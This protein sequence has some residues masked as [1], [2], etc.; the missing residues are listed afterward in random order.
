[1]A[2]LLAS[3]LL[4]AGL[5]A[6]ADMIEPPTAAQLAIPR[7][8]RFDLRQYGGKAGGEALNTAAFEAAVAAIKK[9]GGGELYVP[10]GVWL[11]TGFALTSHMSLFLEKGA[12]IL[13][14]LPNNTH[15]RPRNESCSSYPA[16]IS[17]RG[18]PGTHS[19][20]P[21]N[22]DERHSGYEPIIGGINLTDVHI[23]GNNGTIA[24][25]GDYWWA[26]I[27]GHAAPDGSTCAKP[28]PAKWCALPHGRPHA[29]LMSRCQ[30]VM[31]SNITIT[32]SPFW[33]IRFWASQQLRASDLT[34]TATRTSMNNDGIDVDSSSDAVIENLYYDGGDDGVA[35]KSGECDAG[36]D[37]NTPTTNVRISHVSARTR[38]SC[39]VTGSEDQGGVHNVTV[40]DYA[41]RDSPGGIILK[42]TTLPH[43]AG[44]AEIGFPKSN[45]SFAGVHLHNMSTYWNGQLQTGQGVAIQGVRGFT[46]ANID[47]DVSPGALGSIQ[48]RPSQTCST[49]RAD[50]LTHLGLFSGL[51]TCGFRT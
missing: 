41:C 10:P 49:H 6:A 11:T 40:V 25:Q 20:G 17:C 16:V 33:T 34:I 12:T 46:I 14:A 23:T 39:F 22:T 26:A 2:R 36:A 30:R 3:L 44:V 31:V 5:A 9:A 35:L 38:S 47:G 45:F 43:S 32:E 15:W 24:G 37:F 51:P 13:G 50:L 19:S 21:G 8:Q 42:D 7:Q 18:K 29:V 48:V 28:N 1:M 27:K 4:L